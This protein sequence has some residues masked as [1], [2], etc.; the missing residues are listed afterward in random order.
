MKDTDDDNHVVEAFL[1]ILQ[2]G[3]L[4]NSPALTQFL[5]IVVSTLDFSTK[6]SEGILYSGLY[7][8]VFDRET[9]HY[10]REASA[11]KQHS[12]QVAARAITKTRMEDLVVGK[13]RKVP[14][15][16]TRGGKWL[17]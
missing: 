13:K 1:R 2:R 6:R 5:T 3:R 16:S 12:K 15:S 7:C 8:W 14:I 11:D 10:V 9:G 4:A 17:E